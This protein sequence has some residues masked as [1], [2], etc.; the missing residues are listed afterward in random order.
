[1][2]LHFKCNLKYKFS[3][4]RQFSN[5]FFNPPPQVHYHKLSNEIYIL[6]SD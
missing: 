5:S 4:T 6:Y 1:M 3:E 2:H